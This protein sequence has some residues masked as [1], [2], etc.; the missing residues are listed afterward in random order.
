MGPLWAAETH[1]NRDLTVSYKD[2]QEVPYQVV[3][4]LSLCFGGRFHHLKAKAGQAVP[5]LHH[6]A[7]HGG[8]LEDPQELPMLAVESG[9]D[10][11]HHLKVLPSLGLGEGL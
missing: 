5:V 6:D 10:L 2:L 3:L 4:H 8:V 1:K 11:G 7:A 9:A